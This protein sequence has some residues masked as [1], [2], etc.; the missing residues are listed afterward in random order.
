M[1]AAAVRVSSEKREREQDSVG[2][3]AETGE[4]LGM[5]GGDTLNRKSTN[6]FVR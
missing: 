2:S 3:R 5:C 4:Y 1:A 6:D